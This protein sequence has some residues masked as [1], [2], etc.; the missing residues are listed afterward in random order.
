MTIRFGLLTRLVFG[1]VLPLALAGASCPDTDTTPPEPLVI[2]SA[3]PATAI[4][5]QSYEHTFTTLDGQSPFFWWI[6][7]GRLPSGL[8]LH[9]QTG[10]LDGT[11]S[12]AG[13]FDFT[14]GVRDSS[15]L[16]REGSR[17]FTLTVTPR[18]KVIGASPPPAREGVA[19]SY[20]FTA[21]GGTPPYEFELIGYPLELSFDGVTGILTGTLAISEA[22]REGAPYP[23]QLTI[24]D[25]GQPRQ[26]VVVPNTDL[27]LAVKPASVQITTASLADGNLNA[28]YSQQVVAKYGTPP[29]TWA[30]SGIGTGHILPRGLRL[31]TNA[32]EA[33]LA[34]VPAG[35]V[36]GV[37]KESGVFTI[38]IEVRD[39]DAER[40]TDAQECQLEIKP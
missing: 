24:Q 3:S 22:G 40:T 7:A 9:E 33:L 31:C 1:A 36:Y 27:I 19:Y 15:L 2:Q 10:I 26:K 18:L 25:N 5:G 39:S 32:Q 37:P 12:E 34:G 29:Y 20:R 35:T 16:T 4:E 14:V 6:A 17:D 13:T 38:T 23:M 8:S 30:S 21:E 11:P 28:A